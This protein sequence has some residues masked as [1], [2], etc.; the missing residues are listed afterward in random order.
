[1]LDKLPPSY[2]RVVRLVCRQWEGAAG[3][4]LH[5][6]RPEALAGGR[7][8][9]RFGQLHSLDLSACMT[10]VEYASPK[11]LRLQV[12]CVCVPARTYECM[13]GCVVGGWGGGGARSLHAFDE[14]ECVV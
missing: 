8:G 10:C 11:Q 6:L 3:R 5:Y 7:L 12:C 1:M 4:L 9:A 2:L 14:Q 13:C